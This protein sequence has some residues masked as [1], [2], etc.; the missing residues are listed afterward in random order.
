VLAGGG[1]YYLDE[2]GDTVVVRRRTNLVR[3]PVERDVDVVEQ[4]ELLRPKRA[5]GRR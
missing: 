2:F 1:R 5:R 3:K 4:K